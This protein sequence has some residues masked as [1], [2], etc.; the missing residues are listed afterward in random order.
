MKIFIAV[1]VGV[2]LVGGIIVFSG[3]GDS[4]GEVQ[5]LSYSQIEQDLAGG[6]QL[7][8]VRTPQEY[9]AGHIDDSYNLSLQQIQAGSLPDASQQDKLYI[10]C[11]SGNRSAQAKS[12]LES[13]GYTN[14]IDLGG[15][16]EVSAIGGTVVQ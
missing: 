14:V 6:A 1:L 10:Y 12:L 8:D 4:G 3:N 15:M 7:I 5:G 9:S 11:R 13:A 16:N 2:F